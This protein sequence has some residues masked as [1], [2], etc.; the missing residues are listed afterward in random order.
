[1][2][3]KNKTRL[4]DVDVGAGVDICEGVDIGEGV[5]VDTGGAFWLGRWQSQVQFSEI[6]STF[7]CIYFVI[8]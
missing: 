6:E 8:S 4:T 2:M 3:I 1:M 7:I 5:G